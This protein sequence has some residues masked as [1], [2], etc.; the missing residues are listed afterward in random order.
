MPYAQMDTM[1]TGTQIWQDNDYFL[2]HNFQRI[3]NY[4]FFD[5][6]HILINLHPSHKDLNIKKKHAH[7]HVRDIN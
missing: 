1:N 6:F 4:V 5:I 2:L 3:K 7:K